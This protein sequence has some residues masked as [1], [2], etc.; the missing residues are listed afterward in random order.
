MAKVLSAALRRPVWTEGRSIFWGLL[1]AGVCVWMV[2]CVPGST[3]VLMY[4][5][6]NDD[7]CACI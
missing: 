5:E 1:G 3:C 7:E 4:V 6:V 2:A